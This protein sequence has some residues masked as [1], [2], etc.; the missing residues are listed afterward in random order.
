[1]RE[2]QQRVDGDAQ[3]PTDDPLVAP[4]PPEDPGDIPEEGLNAER[5]LGADGETRQAGEQELEVDYGDYGDRRA[6]T[7]GGEEAEEGATY[8]D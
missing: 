1:M 2:L 8:E 7:A 5:D 6:R 4:N 3:P